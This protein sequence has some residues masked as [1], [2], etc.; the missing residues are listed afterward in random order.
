MKIYRFA[1]L[2][3]AMLA[4]AGCSSFERASFQTLS[5]AKAVLDQAQTDYTAGKI[6]PTPCAYAL[7][8]DGK[9]A[10]TVGVKAL[11]AYDVVYEAKGDTTQVE[12]AVVADLATLASTV[13]E[14][15]ALYTNPAGCSAPTATATP[16]G[17]F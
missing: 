1:A 7:I 16:T 17:G 14:V 3:C 10:Q 6:K 11:E 12:A 4:I 15:K 8:N 13:V 2:A 5:G 9:A